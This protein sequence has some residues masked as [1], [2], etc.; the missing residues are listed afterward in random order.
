MVLSP[1]I[2]PGT[3]V[4]SATPTVPTNSV[5]WVVAIELKGEGRKVFD[6]A[7]AALFA[8]TQAG[9]EQKS[10]F[11]IVLDGEVL[12]A[13]TMQAH[14]TDGASQIQGDFTAESARALSNQLDAQRFDVDAGEGA[15]VQ[16]S[17]DRNDRFSLELIDSDIDDV[18][19]VV[20]S[21]TPT[22]PP[23]VPQQQSPANL[24]R[25]AADSHA[26]AFRV[27][28]LGLVAEVGGVVHYSA[29]AAAAH[30][31]REYAGGA[32][33]QSVDRSRVRQCS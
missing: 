7:S 15:N 30:R 31:L 5:E 23:T 27:A 11:A 6:K 17:T 2:I 24:P 21:A 22:A 26:D 3:D 32:G 8:Q 29:S 13:P 12:S 20:S 16:L 10:R 4:K 33:T 18:R 14:I 28:E 25:T 19:V 9:Q 1:A